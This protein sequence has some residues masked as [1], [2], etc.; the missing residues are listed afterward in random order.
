MASSTSSHRPTGWSHTPT[1]PVLLWLAI[2]LP[3][4]AWDTGYMLMRPH[5]MPGGSLHWPLWVAVLGAWIV[6]P[7]IFMIY[8]MGADIVD[9]LGQPSSTSSRKDE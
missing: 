1:T 7:A 5:T 2:S 6:V 4:V 3:L 8:D 9:G